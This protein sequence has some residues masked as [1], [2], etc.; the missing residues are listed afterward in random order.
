MKSSKDLSHRKQVWLNHLYL[1]WALSMLHKNTYPDFEWLY[2][3]KK[4]KVKK[5]ITYTYSGSLQFLITVVLMPKKAAFVLV[6]PNN[7]IGTYRDI[8]FNKDAIHGRIKHYPYSRG[9]PFLVQMVHVVSIVC[10]SVVEHVAF[11]EGHCCTMLTESIAIH[12]SKYYR[13]A[14][15][16]ILLKTDLIKPPETTEALCILKW[17]YFISSCIQI[18]IV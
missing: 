15:F 4:S 17:K 12:F 8:W 5:K 6:Q 7:T 18:Q 11:F 2:L 14:T 10:P 16:S 1:I 3:L 9:S 13:L